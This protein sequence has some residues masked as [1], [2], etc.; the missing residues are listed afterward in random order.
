MR[1]TPSRLARALSSTGSKTRLQPANVAPGW[2]LDQTLTVVV[3]LEGPTFVNSQPGYETIKV[4]ERTFTAD[5][6]ETIPLNLNWT[7]LPVAFEN[8]ATYRIA[9]FNRV[10]FKRT[11]E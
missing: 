5:F 1:R 3:T 10:A 9:V 8:Y 6:D 7:Q 11:S 2:E 4:F